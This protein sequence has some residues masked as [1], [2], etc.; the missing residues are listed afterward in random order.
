MSAERTPETPG[1]DRIAKL[2]DPVKIEKACEKF[3]WLYY[4]QRTALV[5]EGFR[6]AY[7]L[8]NQEKK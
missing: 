6:A 3:P 8:Y 7:L 4:F 5:Y 2:I 1:T